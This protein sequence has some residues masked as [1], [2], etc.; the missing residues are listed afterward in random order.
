MVTTQTSRGLMMIFWLNSMST[1]ACYI[2]R[3][4]PSWG[5]G[6]VLKL[7]KMSPRILGS[8]HGIIG[9]GLIR[10]RES[11]TVGWSPLPGGEPL[12]MFGHVH[13]KLG[14]NVEPNKKLAR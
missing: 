5:A 11:F 2:R 10:L 3:Y 1:L 9:I 14:C 4:L 13:G 8:Q 7:P 12:I 6:T